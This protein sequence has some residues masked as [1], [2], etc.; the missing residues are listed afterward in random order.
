MPR[1]TLGDLDYHLTTLFPPVRPRGFLEVRYLDA[2]PGRWWRAATGVLWA[3][4]EDE[5]AGDLAAEAAE[6]VAGRWNDAA[7]IGVGAPR[8]QSA[9]LAC[10]VAARDGLARLGQRVVAEELDTFIATYTV[11][12][13]CP[14]D[15]LIELLARD[16]AA[17]ARPESPTLWEVHP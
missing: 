10:L 4:V 5:T 11:R 6:E 14:A 8:L 16:P 12:A 7:R 1:P 9:A 15:D 3:L 17:L 2:L 13:R